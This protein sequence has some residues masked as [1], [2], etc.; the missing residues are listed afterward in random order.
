MAIVRHYTNLNLN[1]SMPCN[2]HIFFI[3]LR[4][5]KKKLKMVHP[6]SGKFMQAYTH[7]VAAAGISD[8]PVKCDDISAIFIYVY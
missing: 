3:D 1:A 2:Q 5:V 7:T 4:F 8:T 6:V